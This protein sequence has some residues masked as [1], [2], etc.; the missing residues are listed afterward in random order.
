MRFTI[1]V[2]FDTHNES[3]ANA[4][5]KDFNTLAEHYKK[6]TELIDDVV[7]ELLPKALNE[8]ADNKTV[9]DPVLGSV[10]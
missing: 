9:I 4:I 7:T 6:Q 8:G 10:G 5:A 3:C 2:S 1:A